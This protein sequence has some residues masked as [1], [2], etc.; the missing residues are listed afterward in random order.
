MESDAKDVKNEYKKWS[1]ASGK[2]QAKYKK[3]SAIEEG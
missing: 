1:K 2:I 3:R